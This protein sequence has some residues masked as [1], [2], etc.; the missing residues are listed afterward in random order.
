MFGVMNYGYLFDLLG[1]YDTW[2]MEEG[3]HLKEGTDFCLGHW[4]RLYREFIILMN[5][6]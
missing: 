1:I 6:P 2:L 3:Q 5:N 4:E